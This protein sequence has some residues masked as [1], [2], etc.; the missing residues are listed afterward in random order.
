NPW[1]Y[2]SI[3]KSRMLSPEGQCKSFD[4]DADGYVPG[5]GVGVVLLQPFRQALNDNNHIYGIFK[6]SAVNHVTGTSSITVPS[7]EA[8][9][10]LI[11]AAAEDAQISLN[12]V[13]YVE[14]HGT[15]T[16]LG[17]PIEVE[18]LTQAFRRHGSQPS[19]CYLGS[20]KT[21]IGHLEAASGIA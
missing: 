11:L 18:A 10:N 1:K 9:R 19:S 21:N 17:D 12:T 13:S 6:G 4:N 15:G 2:I 7:V 20:V 5:E 14:A 16:R 8:Q 3:S